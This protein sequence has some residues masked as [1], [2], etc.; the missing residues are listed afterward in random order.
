VTRQ[1]THGSLSVAHA[2]GLPVLFVWILRLA[3]GAFNRVVDRSIS[4]NK[5]RCVATV[6]LDSDKRRHSRSIY[7]DTYLMWFCSCCFAGQTTLNRGLVYLGLA[8]SR[9]PTREI[10]PEGQGYI[11]IFVCCEDLSMQSLQPFLCLFGWERK[12]F[13]SAGACTATQMQLSVRRS[14]QELSSNKKQ[15]TTKD[16]G[17]EQPIWPRPSYSQGCAYWLARI[18]STDATLLL[19][20]SC[21]SVLRRC[22]SCVLRLAL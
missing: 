6:W 15:N 17:P 10:L 11:G 21:L 18:F 14:T 12:I 22:Q 1:L 13:L 4:G 5:V 16:H 9:V 7:D 2:C 8:S 20:V 3:L 19:A